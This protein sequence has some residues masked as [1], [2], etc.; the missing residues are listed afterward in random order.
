M[1]L[2]ERLTTGRAVAATTGRDPFSELKNRVHLAVIGELGSQLYVNSDG[3]DLRERVIADV[4]AQLAQEVGVSRDD[5]ER[6]AAELRPR[7]DRIA[8]SI[9]AIRE[10][11]L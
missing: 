4:R 1:D 9:D 2:H 11:V 3:V 10:E 7:L 6:L 8:A 5:R